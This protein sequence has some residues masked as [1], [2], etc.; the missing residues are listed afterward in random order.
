MQPTV[1]MPVV[2]FVAAK[3]KEA[4]IAAGL[5]THAAASLVRKRF[6]G[7]SLS[8]SSIANYEKSAGTPGV[9]VIGALAMVYERPINW[10]FESGLPLTG[11]RYRFLSSKTGIKE[12]HQFERQS[13]YWLESYINL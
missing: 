2:G 7:L 3:L 11:I 12:R 10:F 1:R 9:D 13:Q 5:S 4:R 6:P 8:H